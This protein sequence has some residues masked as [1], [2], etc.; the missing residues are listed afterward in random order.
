MDK[1]IEVMIEQL[2]IKLLSNQSEDKTSKVNKF[3]YL[4]KFK[5]LL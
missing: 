2:I 1:Y 4:G 3:H 5:E